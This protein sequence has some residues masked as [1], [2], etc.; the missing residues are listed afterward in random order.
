MPPNWSN[1]VVAAATYD[2]EQHQIP[3]IGRIKQVD[4]CVV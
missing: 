1:P 3:N 2:D 4:L